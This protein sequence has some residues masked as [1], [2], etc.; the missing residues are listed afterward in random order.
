M[1]VEFLLLLRECGHV[2]VGIIDLQRRLV[3]IVE[4]GEEAVV[5]LL[6]DGVE[7]VV[8]A[9]G[10]AD[11]QAEP[12]VAGGGHA[13]EDAVDAELFLV[14]AALLVDLRVAME[15]GGDALGL[16]RV[17]QEVAGELLD[18]ELIKGH[19]LIECPD[20]PV[21][22]FPDLAR[23]INGIAVRVGVA[24][25]VQPPAAPA[26]SMVRACEQ[27]F[28]QRLI[29]CVGVRCRLPHKGLHLGGDWW[30][31]GQVERDTANER[32]RVGERRRFQALCRE[33]V[34]NETIDGM[35]RA[36]EGRGCRAFRRFE[37]PVT[38]V[39]RALLDPGFQNLAL[40]GAERC[41]VGLGRRH[42]VVLVIADDARPHV[43]LGQVSR[44]DAARAFT[45]LRGTLKRV[46]P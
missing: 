3:L 17:R 23:R 36:F 26:L 25:L 43:G 27:T 12:D 10:A 34:L 28:D 30:Q 42:D 21:A 22:E 2:E 7:L 14:D 33:P 32:V 41:L 45:V 31:A 46:E 8:V 13:V 18:G 1:A 24:R 6:L 15:T 40:P 19:V 4:E 39:G 35:R 9:L 37:G 11:G 20:H 5:F 38:L 29:R 16:G 44:D